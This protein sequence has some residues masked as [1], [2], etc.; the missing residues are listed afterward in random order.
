MYPS[1]CLGKVIQMINKDD[2]KEKKLDQLIELTQHN[3]RDVKKLQQSLTNDLSHLRAKLDE[4]LLLQA[5]ILRTYE[6]MK[7]PVVHTA[8]FQFSKQEEQ[9]TEDK[10]IT[11]SAS[12][13]NTQVIVSKNDYTNVTYFTKSSKLKSNRA[14]LA[15]IGI[16]GSIG[17]YL[18]D[19]RIYTSNNLYLRE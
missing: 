5:S 10:P 18:L 19:K 7:L 17:T 2:E 11:F 9:E 6:A 14:I 3:M 15:K 13:Y 4:S 16:E 8:P 1:N 12:Y